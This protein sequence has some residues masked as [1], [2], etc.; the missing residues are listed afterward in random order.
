VAWWLRSPGQA[1]ASFADVQAA[2]KTPRSVTFRQTTQVEGRPAERVRLMI[3]GSGLCRAEEAD[4]NWSITDSSKHQALLVDPHKHEATL[5]LGLN[6]PEANL[7]TL[8]K[9]LPADASAR[10]V[11]GKKI[12][13]KDALGFVVKLEG[14]ELTVW[15]DP[16]NRLPL[17]IETEEKDSE[18]KKSS[19]VIDEFVFDQELDAKRFSFEPPAGYKLQTRGTAAFPAPPADSQLKNL[20]VT[21]L[22]GIGPVKFSMSRA[23]VEKHLGKPDGVEERGKNGYV[24]MSYGSRGFY[25]GVSKTLGVVTISC[26]A[27]K[28]MAVRVRDFSGKTDMGIALDARTADIIRAYGKPDSQETK[29]GSTYLSYNKLQAHFTLFSDK[30]VQMMFTR[31]RAVK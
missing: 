29:T 13:G 6:T 14:H 26:V 17:R 30:L 20:V 9:N 7:Y 5:M 23:D 21:P 12:N 2:M 25:L 27:Q 15:A 28:A 4:G 16:V 24:D 18:G 3:L 11:P 31:P 19:V 8:I 1:R 22:V 10:S